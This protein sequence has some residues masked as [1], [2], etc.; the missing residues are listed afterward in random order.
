MIQ[1]EHEN[2]ESVL[3]KHAVFPSLETL[4]SIFRS[5]PSRL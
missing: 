3:K 1:E 4:N 2:I 5:C